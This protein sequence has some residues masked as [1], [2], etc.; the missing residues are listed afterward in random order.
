VSLTIDANVWLAAA[1][2]REPHRE[3]SARFLAQVLASTEPLESPLLLQVEIV[4]AIARKTG[5]VQDAQELLRE[6]TSIRAQ[7][8]HQLDAGLTSAACALSAD[9]RLRGADAIYVAVAARTGGALITLN[10]EIHS[11]AGAVISVMGPDAWG[12][13][14]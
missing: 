6:V 12:T 3:I 10:R 5:R 1:S 11:R 14:R 13:R 9:L 4:G 8:W 2:D 7:H